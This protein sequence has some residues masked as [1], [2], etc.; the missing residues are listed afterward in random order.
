MEEWFPA[1]PD[2][3]CADLLYSPKWISLLLILA[4]RFPLATLGSHPS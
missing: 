1:V 4:P 3:T 2:W